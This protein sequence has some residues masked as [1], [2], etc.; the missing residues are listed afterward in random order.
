MGM[1]GDIFTAAIP[2]IVTGATGILGNSIT[3][4]REE[5]ARAN[6]LEDQAAQ[7]ILDLRLAA[8]KAQYGSGG[9]GG[10]SGAK[11]P[12]KLT[13]A[14][15]IAAMQNQGDSQQTAIANLIAGMQNA[16]GG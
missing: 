3:Q 9:G 5:E 8:L 6:Q 7:N 10:G 13:A 2:S 15:R 12:N 14:E 16:Y 4:D 1:W 11:D